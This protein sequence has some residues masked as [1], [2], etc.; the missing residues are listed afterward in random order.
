MN[1][2]KLFIPLVICSLLG[3]WITYLGIP[4]PYY[5]EIEPVSGFLVDEVTGE[6]IEGAAVKALWGAQEGYFI[7]PQS[8]GWWLYQYDKTDAR[9]YFYF[10]GVLRSKRK[11]FSSRGVSDYQPRIRVLKSAFRPVSTMAAIH[12]GRHVSYATEKRQKKEWRVEVVKGMVDKTI[13]LERL[14]EDPIER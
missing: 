1:Y 12:A 5:Y 9:G 6:P 4:D 13:K 10:P 14:P 7:R 11:W 8:S 3:I 2:K